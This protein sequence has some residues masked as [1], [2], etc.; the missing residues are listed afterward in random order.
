MPI[1][2]YTLLDGAGAA[3]GTEEFRSSTGP[4]GW[5]YV[6]SI[7]TTDP[8]PHTATVDLTSDDRHRPVRIHLTAGPHSL[9]L[10]PE[11]DVLT[12]TR[13]GEPTEHP[14]EGHVDF[15]SP[16]CNAVTA[17]RL[18]GATE[19]R[20]A[21]VE[22]LT[23]ELR[24]ETQRYERLGNEEVATPVGRFRAECWRYTA[25]SSGWSRRLWVAGLVVVAYEDL[26]ELAAYEPGR[27]GPAPVGL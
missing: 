20:V 23:L 8:E 11:G 26:Y 3:V 22:P 2:T 24:T 16:C 27:T 5:R 9:M 25:L 4:F 12:G 17:A 15:L 19:L 14:W 13:D 6:S 1:G 18:E 7:R 10:T 21:Y